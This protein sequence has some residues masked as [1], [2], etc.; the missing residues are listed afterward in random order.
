MAKTKQIS[1]KQAKNLLKIDEEKLDRY[2][3]YYNGEVLYEPDPQYPHKDFFTETERKNLER[4]RRIFAMFD[5]GRTDEFIRSLISKEFEIEWRQ[6]YNLVSEAYCLYGITGTADKEGK[7]RASI[8]FYRTLA[9]LA[10]KDKDF[11]TAG[12]L[13]E[14][15]DKLEGLFD[16]EESGLDP[17]DFKKPSNYVFINS[18][19][20]FKE[21]QKELDEDD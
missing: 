4:Y 17:N 10:F 20:V 16:A 2:L 13:W 15:A 11:E 12:R 19:N 3:R 9:N 18:M 14:K 5:I 1:L 21:K 8:N 6:A 7:K